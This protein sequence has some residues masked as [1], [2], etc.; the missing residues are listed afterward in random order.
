MSTNK[1]QKTEIN[2][3]EFIDKVN[4]EQKKQ[5]SIKLLKIMEEIIGEKPK[6]WGPSIV[7]FGEYHYK[8]ESG[9]EGDMPLI[10][11]SPRKNALTLYILSGFDEQ[12]KF[13]EKLG[14]YKR[15]RSC[16]YIKSLKDIDEEILRKMIKASAVHTKSKNT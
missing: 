7:G 9:R 3:R 8:Y 4:N 12:D 1:T 5:D 10:G 16:L 6:M 14:K 13:L 11:F 2:P 15:G